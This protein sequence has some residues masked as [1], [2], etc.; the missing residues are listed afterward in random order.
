M[1]NSIFALIAL[2]AVCHNTNAQ[3]VVDEII[4]VVG[5]NPILRSEIEVEYNQLKD[6]LGNIRKDSAF[7]ILINKN[8][9]EKL[10]LHKAQTD[11]IVV[12]DD[13]VEAELDKR[14][15]FY[16]QKFGSEKSMEEYLGKTT[17]QLKS[18]YR[19]K[20]KNQ[21][22]IQEVQQTLLKDVKVSP[23]DIRVYFSKLPV[24]S[25]PYY[26][27][28][29]ELAEIIRNPKVTI[30]EKQYAYQKIVELREKIVAGKDFALLSSVY[31]EDPGSAKRGG[32]LGY[33][34]RNEM[35]PEFEAAAFRL[36][37]DTI[38]K[39]I[40]TKYGYHIMK[41][42]DRKG[43]RIN[44][45]HILIKPSTV[46]EDLQIQKHFLDSIRSQI[47][48]DSIT[49]EDAAKRFSDNEDNKSQG[50]HLTDQMTG[51]GR[52]PVEQ[53]DKETYYMIENMKAGE[54]TGARLSTNEQGEKSYRLVYVKNAYPPHR[55]NLRDD[56]LRIQQAAT[57][58]K[59]QEALE[60]WSKTYRKSSFVRLNPEYRSCDMLRGWVQ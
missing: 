13:R 31:S 5:E 41:L 16:I 58:S 19:D 1:K 38:S 17:Q 44:V 24:D 26:S 56:Y 55:A 30:D 10:M 53:L 12:A 45:R 9:N 3:T 28:E 22:R 42:I 39:I 6:N 52:I 59:K 21:L 32:E 20:I 40:E 47:L 14:L 37:P 18:E 54:I 8:L 36:R 46:E 35:V 29:V 27:A 4:A 48:L 50:G 49:F 57:E 23:T 15:K 34:G 7:C 33:F 43:E 60:T 11:S 51:S 2:F 25:L